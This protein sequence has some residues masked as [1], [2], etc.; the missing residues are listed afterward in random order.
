MAG[1]IRTAMAQL[2]AAKEKMTADMLAEIKSVHEE[3]E[4]TRADGLD[5]MK[6]P[7]A[8]LE[9]TKQEV[10]EIRAEFAPQSNGGPLGPLPDRLSGSQQPSAE[11]AE[12]KT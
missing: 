7:R 5:A 1:E 11:S 6:L 10:R 3:V 12:K 9:S 8:E 4:A 2:R